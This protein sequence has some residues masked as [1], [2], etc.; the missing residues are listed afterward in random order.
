VA[1]TELTRQAVHLYESGKARPSARNLHLIARRIGVPVSA[2]LAGK[3]PASVTP[4][5][6]AEQLEVLCGRHQYEQVLEQ[7]EKTLAAGLPGRLV[8]VVR[9][10]LGYAL[11]R[12]HRPDEALP[13]LDQAQQLFLAYDDPWYAAEAMD[14]QASALHLLGDGRAIETAREALH[15][16]QTLEPRR[17]DS[18]A[19][20]LEHVGTFLWS[21]GDYGSGERY[22]E[23]AL[24]LPG[25][26]H[27]L[28]RL[29]RIFQGLG[30]CRFELGRRDEGL[31]LLAQASEL[32]GIEAQ[33]NP[34][35]TRT[36]LPV[37]RNN[38]AWLLARAGK[39]E[40]ATALIEEALR[41]LDE[42]APQRSRSYLLDTVAEV[43]LRRGDVEGALRAATEALAHAEGAG[44]L[45]AQVLGLQR[46][47]EL[48]AEQGQSE[49]AYR[50]FARALDLIDEGRLTPL[51]AAV[52]GSRDRVVT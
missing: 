41:S 43:R 23:Q 18:E 30:V 34:A 26:L 11:V 35:A 8:A 45:R 44:D 9:Y 28:L 15:Q 46:L 10:C 42:P 20:M 16:Y 21:L 5:T 7:G 49:E 3:P 31:Q 48:Q 25:A 14:W 29:G 24:H 12:L 37:L 33:L 17:A 19:R 22:L 51:R 38:H 50:S 36:L 32:V 47:G 13:H 52:L 6:V 1:G 27:D 39:L 4:E 2:L 40:L